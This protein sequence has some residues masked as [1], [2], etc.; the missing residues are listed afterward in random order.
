M[1]ASEP[2]YLSG[3]D[4]SHYQGEVDWPAVAVS[5]VRFAFIK[6]TD[7]VDDIDPRLRRTGQARRLPASSAVPI[8]FSDHASMRNSRQRISCAWS[9]W[10]TWRY[11]PRS[12][13]KLRTA[14]LHRRFRRASALGW[15]PFRRPAATHRSCTPIRRSGGR[16]APAISARLLMAC[17]L[18]GRARDTCELA[19]LDFLA[20]YRPWKREWYLGPGRPQL[21]R[22]F[23]RG[24]S[25][26]S[27]H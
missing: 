21:L 18:C 15:R 1:P 11:R 27:A 24:S 12:M 19:G 6:A 8:I 3:I 20:A 14:S 16:T 22:T 9:P 10:T 26:T 5:G 25:A 23:V 7:G 17:L 13:W 4:V 2:S